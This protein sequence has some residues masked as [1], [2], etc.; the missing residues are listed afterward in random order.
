MLVGRKKYGGRKMVCLKYPQNRI[1]IGK[2]MTSPEYPEYHQNWTGQYSEKHL[3]LVLFFWL[4][5]L[6]CEKT[7]F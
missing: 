5:K 4:M 1:E 6:I 3:K 7:P 2:M